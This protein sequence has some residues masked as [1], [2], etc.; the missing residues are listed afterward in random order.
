MRDT[1]FRA[2][3]PAFQLVRAA[4][5]EFFKSPVCAEIVHIASAADAA[6]DFSREAGRVQRLIGQRPQFLPPRHLLLHVIKG[7]LVDDW[8]VRIFNV[9][10][11][12]FA[13]VLLPFLEDWIRHVFFLE[14]HIAS[15]GN[16]GQDNLD[17]GIHPAA[18]IP[19]RDAFGGKF[20]FCFK[21]GFA[22]KKILEDTPDNSRFLG[23]YHQFI[24]FPAVPVDT[25]PAVGIPL[26]KLFLDAPPD[27][28]TDGAA[29]FLGKGCQNGH[30]QL[31]V[32]AHGMNIL[33]FKPDFDAQLFQM[34]DGT[35][36]VYSVT[37]ETL[38][39]LG[40][41]NVNLPGFGI[42]QHPQEFL[43]F[44]YPR[45]GNP[46]VSI[47]PGIFPLRV[48]LYEAVVIADLRR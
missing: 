40:Q 5:P 7:F 12:K 18:A 15:I 19:G 17:V 36:K 31:A 30:H 27:I 3:V 13:P 28:F 34:P 42:L 44:L 33:F 39:G 20:S 38:D 32:T 22:V 10:L 1:A 25:E 21:P 23:N 11:G 9:V 45:P 26:L 6:F 43:P 37:G 46:V 41:D 48:L 8:F 2:A 29:F 4:I 47:Y 16:I 35:Q 24:P 14:K